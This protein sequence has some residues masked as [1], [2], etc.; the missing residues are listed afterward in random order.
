MASVTEI[1]QP[2]SAK[3]VKN[4]KATVYFSPKQ[5]D[6]FRQFLAENELDQSGYIRQLIR[7]DVDSYFAEKE[8]NELKLQ[9]LRK[10]AAGGEA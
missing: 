10:M 2:Y 5:F 9:A 7:D 1:T 8:K 3:W 4:H 6:R